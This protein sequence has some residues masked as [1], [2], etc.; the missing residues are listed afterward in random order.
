MKKLK[1]A[2]SFF[3]LTQPTIVVSFLKLHLNKK[4]A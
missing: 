1:K 2:W 4:H 3:S